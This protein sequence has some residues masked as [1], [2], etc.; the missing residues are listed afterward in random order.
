MLDCTLATLTELRITFPR[1]P[2][3]LG[4]LAN[5]RPERE[6]ERC[7]GGRKEAAA[8]TFQRPWLP[9]WL[10]DVRTPVGCSFQLV[11]PLLH[12]QTDSSQDPSP[13]TA[14]QCPGRHS[15]ATPWAFLL[16]TH[17]DDR[18][19]SLP[20]SSN[21]ELSCLSPPH[22]LFH[23]EVREL[24]QVHITISNKRSSK[25]SAFLSMTKLGRKF[26]HSFSSLKAQNCISQPSFSLGYSMNGN[27]RNGGEINESHFSIW[28]LKSSLRFLV[29]TLSDPCMIGN[30]GV[31]DCRATPQEKLQFQNHHLEECC[32][33]Q[34][35]VLRG[36][37]C[38]QETHCWLFY[39]IL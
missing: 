30:A 23:W 39:S 22:F 14:P 35:P 24:P 11:S 37:W 17:L 4:P 18:A 33:G 19:T 9:Q 6:H 31:Q 32:P 2:F 10:A 16:P 27:E 3:P 26:I 34:R 5:S 38:E 1:I 29:H 12:L 15:P 7:L 20:F 25:C 36:L 13:S 21:P 8:S 28:P